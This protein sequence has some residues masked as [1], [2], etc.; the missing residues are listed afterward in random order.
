MKTAGIIILIAGIL[1]TIFTTFKFFTKEKVVDLCKVEISKE[2]PHRF[3]W[4]PVLGI[5]LIG[6]RGVLLWQGS[7]K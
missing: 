1:L 4:S 2:Q 5:A 3:S 6:V 7:K